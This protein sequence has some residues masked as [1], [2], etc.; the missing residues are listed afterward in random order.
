MA[1]FSTY[2]DL[3]DIGMP[4]IIRENPP[5]KYA[6]Y[7]LLAASIFLLIGFIFIRP[8]IGKTALQMQEGVNTWVSSL[9]A[10]IKNVL[11]SQ[12]ERAYI[13]KNG[14]V[15]TYMTGSDYRTNILDEIRL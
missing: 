11:E 12:I 14:A 1:I 3:G 10:P 15:H 4:Q 8:F 9:T 13:D 6:Y 7:L 5:L 2:K